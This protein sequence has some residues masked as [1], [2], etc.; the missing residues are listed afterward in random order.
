MDAAG[1]KKLVTKH[2]A[3]KIRELGWKGS[4]FHFRKVEDNHIVKVFGFQ[5]AWYGGSVCCETAIH[6]DF[7]PDLAQDNVD[8]NK[9]TYASCL[10]RERLSPK[11]DGDY[12]WNFRDSEADNIESINQIWES[13]EKHGTRFY[14]SFNDFPNPFD[15]IK[16]KDLKKRNYRLIKNCFISNMI[17]FAWILKEINLKIGK[18]NNAQEFAD[19]GLDEANKWAKEL[20]KNNRGKIDYEYL[21]IYEDK[22]KITSP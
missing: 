13:F 21:R 4:G 19:Y 2:F 22:F 11:G 18:Y 10:I 3:P 1:F 15:K 8:V 7:I 20:A 14:N 17:E 6:F 12:H 5:G 16:V 9:I